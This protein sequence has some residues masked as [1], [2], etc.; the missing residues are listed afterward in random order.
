MSIPNAWM[1]LYVGDYLRDTGHLSYGQHG[2]YLLLLMHAWTHAGE[3]PTDGAQLSMIARMPAHE[4]KRS[5]PVIL[6]FFQRHGDTLRHK[7]IDRELGR[8]TKV[9]EKRRSAGKASAEARARRKSD[10]EIG[11]EKPTETA[12]ATP[13]NGQQNGSICSTSVADVLEQNAR[14]PQ[15]QPQRRKK[16]SPGLRPVVILADDPGGIPPPSDRLPE[17]PKPSDRPTTSRVST[18][19]ILDWAVTVWNRVC[20][21]KLSPVV[22]V[23]K[24]R[25]DTF[26]R[27]WR[28]DF[29]EDAEAWERYCQRIAASPFLTDANGKNRAR[30]RANFDFVLEPRNLVR[31]EEGLWDPVAEPEKHD[32]WAWVDK[33][34]DPAAAS[35]GAGPDFDMEA[36]ADDEGTYRPH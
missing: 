1:P 8:A 27:R 21:G 33:L 11:D 7:R 5:S 13:P 26:M 22:K 32:P 4:W 2:S 28:E 15:P 6:A 10:D 31:I 18:T 25:S 29:H 20:G 12:A 34:N 23:T 3:L 16:K 24:T 14:Q 19:A 35:R 9:S 17:E 36:T 30:W